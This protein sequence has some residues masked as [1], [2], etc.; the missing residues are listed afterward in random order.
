MELFSWL[1]IRDLQMAMSRREQQASWKEDHL[2]QEVADVQQVC[3][4][5]QRHFPVANCACM[6]V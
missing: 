4:V 6:C 5:F 1:Q 3:C 2:K